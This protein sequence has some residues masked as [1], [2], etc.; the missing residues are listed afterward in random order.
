MSRWNE[1]S[2]NVLECVDANRAALTALE[3]GRSV[4]LEA[5]GRPGYPRLPEE[6]LML[7]QNLGLMHKWA[8]RCARGPKSSQ[9]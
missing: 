3:H 7:K 2:F 9:V 4:M 6:T 5:S 1:F 8:F